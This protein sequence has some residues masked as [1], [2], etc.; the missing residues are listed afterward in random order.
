[1]NIADPSLAMVDMAF[2]RRFAFV[3]LEPC[4]GTTMRD[5]VVGS[6][7]VQPTR[8]SSGWCSS[9]TPSPRTAAS[10]KPSASATAL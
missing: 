8:S 3:D 4:L 2:R 6:M 1:M 5:L 9:T 10:A 7:R